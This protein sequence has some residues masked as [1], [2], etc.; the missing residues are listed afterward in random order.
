MKGSFYFKVLFIIALGL[1]NSA[2]VQAQEPGP[3]PLTP[4]GEIEDPLAPVRL[5]PGRQAFGPA[6]SQATEDWDFEVGADYG[7]VASASLKQGLGSVTE[8]SAEVGVLASRTHSG[9]PN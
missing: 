3:G 5:S 6:K 7:Y 9:Y 1:F 4:E 8:Q 2:F